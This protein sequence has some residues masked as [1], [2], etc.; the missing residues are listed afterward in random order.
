[1]FLTSSHLFW[2]SMLLIVDGFATEECGFFYR[3]HDGR[4]GQGT[5]PKTMGTL[6]STHGTVLVSYLF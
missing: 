6:L 4:F 2:M 5:H 3:G 1:M